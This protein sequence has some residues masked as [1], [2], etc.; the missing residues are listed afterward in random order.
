M[1]VRS[2]L[3]PTTVPVSAMA[4]RV[5]ALRKHLEQA[6]RFTVIL[7]GP[8]E[9]YGLSFLVEKILELEGGKAR[10]LCR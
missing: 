7:Q 6:S 1:S 2:V 8:G 4:A 5:F 9:G 3:H 10:V